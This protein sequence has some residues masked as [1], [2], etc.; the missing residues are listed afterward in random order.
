[1]NVSPNFWPAL[2]LIVIGSVVAVVAGPVGLV[3]G[4][5]LIVAAFFVLSRG[6]RRARTT[7]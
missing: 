6:R 5:L 7:R 2:A 1:V 4:I 3:I